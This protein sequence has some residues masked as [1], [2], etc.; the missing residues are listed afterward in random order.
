MSEDDRDKVKDCQFKLHKEYSYDGSG[1]VYYYFTVYRNN[2]VVGEINMYYNSNTYFGLV[3]NEIK[4]SNYE[5]NYSYTLTLYE[6]SK[7]NFSSKNIENPFDDSKL[8]CK[9]CGKVFCTCNKFFT[10]KD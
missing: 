8:R 9:K 2:I 7:E 10:R 6:D 1:D 5:P 4:T 3:N